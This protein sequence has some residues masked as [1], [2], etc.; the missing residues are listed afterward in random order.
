MFLSN[1]PKVVVRI[2]D[3]MSSLRKWDEEGCFQNL[4][5]LSLGE[6]SVSLKHSDRFDNI[7]LVTVVSR[8]DIKGKLKGYITYQVNNFY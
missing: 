2:S 1:F 4:C 8:E 6:K 5:F 3:I 7:S